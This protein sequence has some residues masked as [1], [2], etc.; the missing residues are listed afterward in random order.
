[1][2]CLLDTQTSVLICKLERFHMDSNLISIGRKKLIL[3]PKMYC[4]NM[5]SSRLFVWSV[6]ME[7]SIDQFSQWKTWICVSMPSKLN[8]YNKWNLFYKRG[9]KVIQVS[10]VPGCAWSSSSLASCNYCVERARPP[11]VSTGL[12]DDCS[13]RVWKTCSGCCDENIQ[14]FTRS[15]FISFII[16]DQ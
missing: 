6:I 8:P 13:S 3:Y 2:T 14:W 5:K 9:E 4:V 12:M 16:K 1:M 10:H 15:L 11:S 7:S